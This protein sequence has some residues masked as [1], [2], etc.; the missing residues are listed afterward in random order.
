[1]SVIK[2]NNTKCP[3]HLL[4]LQM[5]TFVLWVQIY[6]VLIKFLLIEIN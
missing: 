1:M 3:F 5:I 4:C 2:Q 6:P